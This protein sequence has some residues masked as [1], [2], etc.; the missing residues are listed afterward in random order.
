MIDIFTAYGNTAT[1]ANMAPNRERKRDIEDREMDRPTRLF[2][3]LKNAMSNGNRQEI[4]Q[5]S[6]EITK[7]WIAYN[8]K[9]LI[10]IPEW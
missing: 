3:L 2:R 6:A 8:R 10:Q 1:A 5:L 7:I 4:Q 9:C